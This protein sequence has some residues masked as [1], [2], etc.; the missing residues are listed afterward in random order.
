M[1]FK[2]LCRILAE[3]QT[4]LVS[5]RWSLSVESFPG[6]AVIRLHTAAVKVNRCDW[7]I[8][9]SA[10]FGNATS[11]RDSSAAPQSF[12]FASCAFQVYHQVLAQAIY[13][14][15][16]PTLCYWMHSEKD[17][18]TKLKVKKK[19]IEW[20]WLLIEKVSIGYVLIISRVPP[21]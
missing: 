14:S 7:F 17:Q 9:C 12:C 3:I 21:L 4:T 19:W 2:F 20:R 13:K 18:L 16:S 10:W 8:T 15:S 5:I 11:D 6:S 1:I